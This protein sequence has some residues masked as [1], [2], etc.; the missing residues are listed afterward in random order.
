MRLLLDTVAFIFLAENNA[1][2]SQ[3]ARN[4]IDNP[5]NELFLSAASVWEIAIKYS[6]GR[7]ELMVPPEE[8]VPE[9]R[10]LHHIEPL[11]ISERDALQV[12]KLPD[13]HRDP[14][15][16]LILAQAMVQDMAVVTNDSLMR[17]YAVPTLW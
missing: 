17:R 13:I 9:Q 7:L 1:E 16:R 4:L 8:Y 11:P 5:A 14:F 12:G 2:L 6:I 3:S 10:R 15:D